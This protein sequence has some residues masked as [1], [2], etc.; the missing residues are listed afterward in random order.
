LNKTELVGKVS[1]LSGLPKREAEAALESVLHAIKSAVR[2]NETVRITGFGT[3]KGRDRAA[4]RGRNPQTGAPVRIKASKGIGFSAGA[5]LKNELNS[6]APLTKPV[7]VGAATASA[8]KA[9]PAR[10]AAPAKKAAP[11]RKAA[12][13]KKAAPVRKAAPAK[14][15]PAKRA[16]AKRAAPV[17]KAAAPAR[18]T[19]PARKAAPAKRAPARKAA[20]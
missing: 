1:E 20:R 2:G 12:P 5:T 6:R 13:A 11:A 14:K 18:K 9:A 8:A 15:A 4:R 10:K 3:F 16:P 7:P 17:R 19:A